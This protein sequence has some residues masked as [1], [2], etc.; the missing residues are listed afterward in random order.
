MQAAVPAWEQNTEEMTSGHS[1]SLVTKSDTVFDGQ[2]KN[3]Y[4]HGKATVQF[5]DDSS[6]EG[7]VAANVLSGLGVMT[8]PGCQYH[9]QLLDGLFH[10]KG[11]LTISANG[12][13]YQG[14]HVSPTRLSGILYL[15][16]LS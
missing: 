2:L 5:A 1:I 8:Y 16:P 4:I 3:G 15:F 7:L 6:F 14:E 12:S 10:G 9:G 13:M 11:T